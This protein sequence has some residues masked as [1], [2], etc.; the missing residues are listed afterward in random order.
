METRR[1]T[2][3]QAAFSPIVAAVD[4]NVEITPIGASAGGPEQ[5]SP[6]RVV[7]TYS[8]GQRAV[9]V[10]STAERRRV[11]TELSTVD[12]EVAVVGEIGIGVGVTGD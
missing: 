7:F 5:R 4:K 2:N 9:Q 1:R 12:I 3:A 11:D 6:V 10:K 8:S